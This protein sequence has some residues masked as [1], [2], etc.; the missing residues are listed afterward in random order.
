MGVVNTKSAEITAMDAP[1]SATKVPVRGELIT[2]RPIVTSG[3]CAIAA[4][5]DDGSVYRVCRVHSSWVI[6]EIIRKNDAITGASDYDLGLY[7][8]ADVNNGAVVS[9]AANLFADGID[10]SAGTLLGVDHRS[11]AGADEAGVANLNKRV[12]ELLGL[13]V[14]PNKWYDLAWTS[15]TNGSGA[16]NIYT[17]VVARALV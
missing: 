17:R 7:D 4:G 5:D 6:D 12:F 8:I 15:T 1:P 9:G 16:G 13:S 10:I 11:D 3:I 14:D 2:G